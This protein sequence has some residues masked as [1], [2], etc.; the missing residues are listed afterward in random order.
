MGRPI[1]EKQTQRK[2]TTPEF[3]AFRSRASGYCHTAASEILGKNG[4]FKRFGEMRLIESEGLAI[5]CPRMPE[6]KLTL[7][8]ER[9]ISS[10]RESSSVDFSRHV[11]LPS[12]PAGEGAEGAV[13]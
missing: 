4:V 1:G 2:P 5:V 3:A 10:P 9:H 6:V 8:P 12:D 13:S 7:G 11:A